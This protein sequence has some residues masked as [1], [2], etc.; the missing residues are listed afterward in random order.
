VIESW[1]NERG[2]RIVA[3]RG[4]SR[5]IYDLPVSVI[6]NAASL[7]ATRWVILNQMMEQIKDFS[8]SEGDRDLTLH[9]DSR[10]IEE[11]QGELTPDT[12]FAKSS[13]QY[14]IENDYVT[15]RRVDFKKCASNTINGKLSE[16][17]TSK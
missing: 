8:E 3:Q 13:L 14:F 11:L 6:D 15:F 9:T 4:E 12:S 16:P 10:L 5:F 17:V 1:F 7:Y 2:Y